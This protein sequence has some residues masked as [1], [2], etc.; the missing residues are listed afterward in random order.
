MSERPPPPVVVPLTHAGIRYQQDASLQPDGP[1]T[2]RGAWLAAFDANSGAP[3]WSAL[4]YELAE[5]PD[6]PVDLDMDR[7]FKSLALLADESGIDVEDEAG[8]HYLFDFATRVARDVTSVPGRQQPQEDPLA[9]ALPP[10]APAPQDD[11]PFEFPS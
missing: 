3:L 9:W 2:P 6:S 1:G 4:V 11:E 5:D 8:Y 10:A 7:R